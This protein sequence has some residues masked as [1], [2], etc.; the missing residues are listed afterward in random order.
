MNVRTLLFLLTAAALAGCAPTQEVLRAGVCG[1]V[2]DARTGRP[3]PRAVVVVENAQSTP[4]LTPQIATTWSADDGTFHLR[5]LTRLREFRQDTAGQR[6]AASP[7]TISR[8]GYAAHRLE[9][10]TPLF[11]TES[12]AVVDAGKVELRPLAR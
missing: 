2:V 10:R 1:A 12:G 11:T 5:A 7:L 4:D 9:L 6:T 8:A 3:I